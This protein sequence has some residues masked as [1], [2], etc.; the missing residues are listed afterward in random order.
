M[1]RVLIFFALILLS[2]IPEAFS[3]GNTDK[4]A[5][6]EDPCIQ[7]EEKTY[8]WRL[9]PYLGTRYAVA[10]DTTAL[11]YY[12]TDVED[13]FTTAYNYLANF[14]SP[15]ESRIFFSRMRTP[16]F[17]FMKAYER[18]NVSPDKATFYNTQIPFTQLA[19][20][21]GG[22]KQNAEDRLKGTFW[23]NVNKR[24]GLGASIDYMS[25]ALI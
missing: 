6:A 23:G 10:L 2:G 21:T 18:F 13:S 16:E 11:N 4:N 22:S 15:G 14:G 24:L 8:S 25:T 9:S 1:K 19:Y 17:I 3:Q 7:H 20:L 5:P 12:N